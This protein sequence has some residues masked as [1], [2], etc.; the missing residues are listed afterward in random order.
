MMLHVKLFFVESLIV[1]ADVFPGLSKGFWAKRAATCRNLL[2]WMSLAAVRVTD[3]S[4][5][6]A[7]APALVNR[8]TGR[9]RSNFSFESVDTAH[10]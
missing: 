6:H 3:S 4:A 2:V 7:A 1:E 5:I 10:P 9:E 8:Y